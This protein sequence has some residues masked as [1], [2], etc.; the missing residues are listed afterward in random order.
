MSFLI[1]VSISNYTAQVTANNVIQSASG[2]ITSLDQGIERGYRFCGW[3]SL[4]KPI[5]RTYPRLAGLYVPK[6]DGKDVFQGMD[7]GEC[8]AAII[9]DVAWQVALGGEFSKAEDGP[10]YANHPTGPA[11]Y[12][13]DTKLMLPTA[14]YTTKA[15]TVPILFALC[16][17]T[18]RRALCVL[19]RYTIDIALPVRSDLQRLLSWLLTVQKDAGEWNVAD[20]SARQR[21]IAT[22]TCTYE[23]RARMRA[24]VAR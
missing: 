7:K 6:G 23:V 2:S 16:I 11:R 17:P 13:C 20:V 5:E 15:H 3:A 8:E 12:H 9:D 22:S 19:H 24:E 18:D 4:Q 14:V 21:F 10:V 1:L